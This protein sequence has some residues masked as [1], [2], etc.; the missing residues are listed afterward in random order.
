[1]G[2]NLLLK[3]SRLRNFFSYLGT[4]FPEFSMIS[5]VTLYWAYSIKSPLN[6]GVRHIMP[7]LPF[8]YILST[9]ALKKW[10]SFRFVLEGNFLKTLLKAVI[11]AFKKSAKLAI[12]LVLIVW[13]LLESLIVSP[14][15]LSYF[16]QLAGGTENGYRQV[17]DSNYDWGQDMKYLKIFAEKNNI[18]K[19][20]VDYFG[21]G[22]AG[23]YLGDKAEGWWSS[24]GNPAA[25]NI[26]WIAISINNL[27]GAIGRA[28]PGFERKSADEYR[29]L[30]NLKKDRIYQPDARAGTSIFIYKL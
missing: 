29:W 1:M 22:S 2:K 13:Y 30:Q 14:H 3:K 9:A 5:F 7:T 26:N 27:Q 12:I 6:I 23:Y 20:A 8:I 19:I 21:G 28:A 10:V 24:R 16:N 17:T 18:D 15:F 11:D 25:E 4:N